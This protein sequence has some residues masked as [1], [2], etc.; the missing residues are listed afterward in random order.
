MSEE[1][2]IQPSTALIVIGNAMFF[3]P[4]EDVLA[5]TIF[6]KGSLA[7]ALS[8]AAPSSL[9]NIHIVVKGSEVFQLYD[10]GALSSFRPLLQPGAQVTFHVLSNP[11]PEQ[12]DTIKMSLVMSEFK[13]EAEQEGPDGTIIMVGKKVE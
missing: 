10:E 8:H 11:S 2:E 7:S 9:E 12:L 4:E 6:A 13:L 5:V 3:R 1:E